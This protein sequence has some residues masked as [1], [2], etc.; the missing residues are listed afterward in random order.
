MYLKYSVAPHTPLRV[1]AN[2][3]TYSHESP[4]HRNGHRRRQGIF[5]HCVEPKAENPISSKAPSPVFPKHASLLPCHPGLPLLSRYALVR[6]HVL[7]DYATRGGGV[8]VDRKST[9]VSQGWIK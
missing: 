6:H 3:P 7:H 4:G 5:V 8:E 9:G 2:Q 1:G